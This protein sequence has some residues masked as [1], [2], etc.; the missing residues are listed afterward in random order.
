MKKDKVKGDNRKA[1]PKFL[2]TIFV[3][4]LGGGVVGALTSMAGRY[5]LWETVSAGLDQ[6]M[7]VLALWGYPV[8]AVVLLAGSWWKYRSAKKGFA[9]WD[10][11][12]EDVIDRA[13]LALSWTMLLLSALLILSLFFFT[14]SVRYLGFGLPLVGIMAFFI[15]SMT[16][17]VLI[18]QKTVDLTKRMN[19]EKQGSVYDTKFQKKWLASCDEAEQKQIGQAAYRAFNVTNVTC[20]VLWLGLTVLGMSFDIGLLPVVMVTVIW[21][22]LQMTYMFTAISLSKH[23]D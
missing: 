2:L 10:G 5:G 16:A 6:V 7:E 3:A 22:V 14:V 12:D 13:E 20:I 19:P 23:K 8:S 1:M 17:T 18:Q 4:G 21:G 15:L 11:E 9:A